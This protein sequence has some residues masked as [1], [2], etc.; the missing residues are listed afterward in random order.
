[1]FGPQ[2]SHIEKMS[3]G[4]RIPLNRRQGVF[5]VQL[6]A[7]AGT[8]LTKTAKFDEPNT[9]LVFRWPARTQ[10]KMRKCKDNTEFLQRETKHA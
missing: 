8:R 1:M 6:D 10:T 7:R 5:V 9:N 4:Q 3:T 2:E